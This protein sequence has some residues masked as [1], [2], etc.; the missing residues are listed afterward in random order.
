M[1]SSPKD[2]DIS[3]QTLEKKMKHNPSLKPLTNIDWRLMIKHKG[4]HY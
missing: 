4:G 2:V 3:R 1:E